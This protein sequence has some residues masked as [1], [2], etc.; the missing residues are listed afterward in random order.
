MSSYIHFTEEQKQRAAAVDLEEFLRCRGE[1]LLSSGR[2]KRLASDHSVTVRGN[3]WYDHAEERGG[4][5]VSFVQRFYGLSYPDAVTL[6][7]GGELGTAYP[8]AGERTEEP[9]KPFALPPANKEMRRVFAYLSPFI[10][11]FICRTFCSLIPSDICSELAAYYGLSYWYRRT[12][13]ATN[14][15][16]KTLCVGQFLSRSKFDEISQSNLRFPLA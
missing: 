6:L 4:H 9:V 14:R 2:E 10:E 3:E 12:I 5:A 7:L 11:Y 15:Y 13:G 16:S 8:S 1:K